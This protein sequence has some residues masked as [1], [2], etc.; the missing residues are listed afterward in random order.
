MKKELNGLKFFMPLI[1][2]IWGLGGA[3]I[4]AIPLKSDNFV[5]SENL[6]STLLES[7]IVAVTI[8]IAIKFIPKLFSN[9]SNYSVKKPQVP[10][11]LAILLV[12]PFIKILEYDFIYKISYAE[13]SNIEILP[14]ITDSFPETLF[15]S[16]SAVLLA[17]VLEELTFRYMALSPFKKRSSKIIVLIV[18]NYV[19]HSSNY[20][21]ATIDAIVLG[22]IFLSSKNII[23]PI[24]CHSFTN[25]TSTIFGI[26]STFNI[27]KITY[28]NGKPIALLFTTNAHICFGI[29]FF[30]GIIVLCLSAK[31]FI[32]E[33]IFSSAFCICSSTL[34]K[35]PHRLCRIRFGFPLRHHNKTA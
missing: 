33:S 6:L 9:C 28:T 23:Y 21:A 14:F 15:E 5:L 30:I 25:L 20:I 19:V 11:I 16:I 32:I 29:L 26:L 10:I 2:I 7:V 24:I 31:L 12:I 13:S 22:I 17:P 35:K 4:A 8:F 34:D 27:T 3:C 1:A 18:K